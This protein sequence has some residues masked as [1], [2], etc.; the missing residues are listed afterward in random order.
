MA[1]LFKKVTGFLTVP[2][3]RFLSGLRLGMRAKLIIIFVLIKVIPLVILT[4]LA[5]RQASLLGGE[6]AVRAQELMGRANEA[7]AETGE[8][9]V[10]DSV[11]AINESAT[12]DIERLST[13]MARRVADFLYE[14]DGDI[15]YAAGL[16]PDE[17]AYR[18]FVEARRRRILAPGEWVLAGDG[19]SWVPAA[20][21]DGG[22]LVSSSNPEN[23]RNFNYR[24][25][26]SF[27]YESR[28]LYL[29]MSFVDLAGNERVK[30]TTS[31]RMDGRLKNVANRLNTY[32]KAESYFGELKRLKAGEI[33]VS[34]VIGAY[35]PSRLIGMYTPGE[36]QARG[37]EFRPEEEAYAGR[38]NPVG[39]R[40]KGIV[41]WAAPVVRGGAITGYVT[42]ALDHDH[43]MEFADHVTPVQ[44]RYTELPSAF[45][46]NYAFMWDYKCRNISHPRHHSIVG[47]DPQTGEPMVP[48]LEEGMYGQWRSSGKSYAE[49]I[50]DQPVFLEQS[51][52]K[53]LARELEERG[54]VGLD[55]RYLNNAPQCTG[56]FDLTR[57]GGSGSFL[58]QWGG[59]WKL[60]TAAAIP[61][62]TGRYGLSRRG[63]GFVT[64]GADFEDFEHSA[65]ETEKLLA[66][67]IMGANRELGEA[68]NEAQNAIAENLF[69]TAMG[70]LV[71]AGVMVLFVVLIAIW[72][73]SVFTGSITRLVEGIS[74]FRSGE[75]Q[76]RFHA[77]V[78]DELG[79]LAD[80]FDAMAE[81]LE[82][83]VTQP[84]VITDLDRKII[85]M[86]RAGLEKSGACL[87][88]LLGKSYGELS[89]YPRGSKSDPIAALEEG[90]EAE[91]IF[92]EKERRYIRGSASYQMDGEGRKIGYI[93][94]STDVT[95]S[96][97]RRIEL[98]KAVSAANK[99]NAHKGEFLARMSHEIRTPMNAIIGMTNIVK[100]RLAEKTV[101]MEEV[102]SHVRQIEASSQHL[103]GLLNDILDLSKIEA[104][105]IELAEEELDLLKLA[106]TVEV[107]IR[108]RCSE[109]N[110]AFEVHFDFD[111]PAVFSGDPLRLRQVLLN[112]LGNAVKFTPD[113]GTLDFSITQRDKKEGKTLL[114]FS[115]RDSGIGISGEALASLFRPF[116]QASSQIT[117]RYGGTGLGL[118]I[119]KSIV[120][121]F[122][123][124]IR[125]HS[126]VGKGSQFSFSLWLTDREASG[127]EE[128]A[129]EDATGMFQGKRALLVDD[130][131]IN[132]VIAVNL[133]EYTGLAMDEAADGIE[134]L[135][136]FENSAPG[137]YDIIYM[138]IQMPRMDGY[139]AASAIRAL[140]R[141][142]AKTVP[143]V[144]LTANAFKDD[145]DNALRHG[146]NAH[147]AK[148]FEIEKFI[149]ITFRLVNPRKHGAEPM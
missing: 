38:E 121:L 133:L 87:S 24:R 143:I 116:E 130:V 108:S 13:D 18:H 97:E 63:F 30:V 36:A 99:A 148:P 149:E 23:Q 98:E 127:G 58:I 104:G 92:L 43:I 129:A 85:F 46:G 140:D 141:S 11:K 70:L 110:L 48:W 134:A 115:V 32:V 81:G 39:R 19:G 69:S 77:S 86:N 44:E 2:V 142:D 27:A 126:E 5:W 112:L 124:D 106:N 147:I 35:V 52:K 136:A 59:I 49:F 29:E 51:R 96:V 20:A 138:D 111:A 40:F 135:E 128:V 64:I 61:Y 114:D 42:L 80:S 26:E 33:Y 21:G 103:L 28:P 109:K 88:A 137:D 54:L 78:K 118:A 16:A 139:E 95:E 65:R 94:V 117:Q 122:G 14:R 1:F 66:E 15:L 37:L 107:I 72:M 145:I 90:R 125:V 67:V 34:D 53:R 50:R 132:R 71:S 93:I 10:L 25:P 89:V 7:L 144:A 131:E 105:K 56:W 17:G 79:M 47:Y 41:R 76:F 82:A 102:C 45:E 119:S 75:R 113:G 83:S 73:A 4:F 6:L 60:T 62:Y 123:G 91:A 84:L 55:G 9:A 74:R 68:A 3:E 146:M 57:E 31:P 120:G 8:I 100:K 22:E 101:N 12:D